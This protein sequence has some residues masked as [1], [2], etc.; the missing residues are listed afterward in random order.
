MVP[1]VNQIFVKFCTVNSV[2]DPD[3]N[4]DLSDPYPNPDTIQ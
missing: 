1:T 4:P 3:P 2:A